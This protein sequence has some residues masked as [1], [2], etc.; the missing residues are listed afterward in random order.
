M[1]TLCLLP[2][3]PAYAI[4]KCQDS[5]GR[6]HYGDIAIAKCNASKVTT[7]NDRGFIASEKDAPKTD[8]QLKKESEVKAEADAELARVRALEDERN[9]VL[10]VYETE[11]DID[12]Q[13]DNQVDS[14]DSNIAV[15]KAY[16]KS[17]NAKIERLKLKGVNFK[18]AGKKRNEEQISQ[19]QMRVKESMTEL[20]K[21]VL[22]KK[23]IMQRFSREKKIYLELTNPA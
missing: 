11:A 16:V 21:L 3:S 2:L 15:H 14:V 8:E 17:L 5:D 19:A 1:L 13:R 18:G 10:S 6:W 7:L 23:S 4:K 12:R 9:R 20:E 22:Q